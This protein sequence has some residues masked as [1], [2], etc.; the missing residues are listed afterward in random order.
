MNS[1]S[2]AAIR[3]SGA[4]VRLE[5]C[6]SFRQRIVLSVLSGR[7]LLIAKVRE[8]GYENPG[9]RGFEAGFLRLVDKVTNGS[10]IEINETGTVLRFL[11]G[12]V[13]GGKHKHDCGTERSIGYFLEGIVPLI[14]FG[15]Q[16][17]TLDLTGI[18]NDCTDMSVDSI[19]RVMFPYMRVF[20]IGARENDLGLGVS[21]EMVLKVRKRGARPNGGGE[22]HFECPIVRQLKPVRLME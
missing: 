4:S 3:S 16:P 5:G 12:M 20:G 18:T 21:N 11:P 13:M 14:V 7:P 19:H 15:K 8:R 17:T 2:K 10:T 6:Q 9:L 22:V 1:A